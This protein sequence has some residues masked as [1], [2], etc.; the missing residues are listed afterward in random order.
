MGGSS[1]P[2]HKRGGIEQLR[3][4]NFLKGSWNLT[5]VFDLI[6]AQECWERHPEIFWEFLKFFTVSKKELKVVFA[7]AKSFTPSLPCPVPMSIWGWT[8]FKQLCTFASPPPSHTHTL[9]FPY[10]FF[11]RFIFAPVWHVSNTYAVLHTTSSLPHLFSSAEIFLQLSWWMCGTLTGFKHLCI[12]IYFSA[13][14][15]PGP[16]RSM[17]FCRCDTF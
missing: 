11:S 12:P 14:T 16:F 8:A 6:K 13:N 17:L 1:S 9:F 15:S 4:F 3:V 5:Q 10:T 7:S 2:L